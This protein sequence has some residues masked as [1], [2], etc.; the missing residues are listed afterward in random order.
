MVSVWSLLALARH[1][2]VVGGL[3]GAP[4]WAGEAE[5]QACCRAAGLASC[6][7]ELRVYDDGARIT[8]DPGG[9]ALTGLWV[10][11]C[12]G[13]AHFDPDAVVYLDHA[14]RREEIAMPE[15]DPA[16]ITCFAQSCQLP[17]D[18]CVSTPDAAG[19]R[20][21]NTCSS[22]YEPG[23]GALQR[24]PAPRANAVRVSMDGRVFDAGVV[25]APTGGMSTGGK[26]TGGSGA[27]GT[28][29]S[30]TS[31]SGTST[32]APNTVA[33]TSA[34][35]PAPVGSVTVADPVASLIAGLPPDPSPSCSPASDAV[36][37]EARQL[38]LYGDDLRLA[39]D[40]NGALARFRAALTVDRCNPYGWMGLGQAASA[41]SRPDLAI[42]A[43]RNTVSLMPKHYGAWTELGKAY[44]AIGQ[45][46][47]ARTAYEQALALNPAYP[48]AVAGAARMGQRAAP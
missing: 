13:T 4:A 15:V 46:T 38:V 35:V 24:P 37:I 26:T 22:G 34:A 43:L 14:P 6:G 42:R 44:E 11:S 25:T 39:G 28:S 21:L 17:A 8:R 48:E 10:V 30:G 27:G 45:S 9:W 2:A 33:A 1:T 29:A 12:D 7:A 36:R 32:S 3:F 18:L 20:F 47:L 40:N 23:P 19:N 31:T 16:E 41:L 5:C